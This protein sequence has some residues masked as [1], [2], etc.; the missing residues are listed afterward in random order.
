ML[1]YE[2]G[3]VYDPDIGRKEDDCGR[4]ERL[5]AVCDV[6]HCNEDQRNSDITVHYIFTPDGQIKEIHL[7]EYHLEEIKRKGFLN[8]VSGGDYYDNDK[9][10]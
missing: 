1:T 2:G 5:I 9:E 4:L 6:E 7:C 10:L 8:N 3:G